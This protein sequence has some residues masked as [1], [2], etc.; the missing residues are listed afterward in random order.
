MNEKVFHDKFEKALTSTV[1]GQL[2]TADFNE[3]IS[4]LRD[5]SLLLSRLK[6][7]SMKANVE[8]IH[9][10]AIASG[11]S[12]IGTEDTQETT[13]SATIPNN[14]ITAGEIVVDFPI[15]YQF[16]EDQVWSAADGPDAIDDAVQQGLALIQEEIVKYASNEI[17]REA[18][19]TSSAGFTDSLIDVA[20]QDANVVDID[21]P[22]TG[23]S[24]LL[25][26][27]FASLIFLTASLGQ[28]EGT[29]LDME[30]NPNDYAYIVSRNHY[31]N[32]R[33]ELEDLAVDGGFNMIVDGGVLKYNDVPVHWYPNW[34]D[35]HI[36]LASYNDLVWGV[37]KN[38][39][40]ETDKDVRRRRYDNVLTA[41][42]GFG[43][44]DSSKV[45]LLHFIG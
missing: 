6:L 22:L 36:M 8:E 39:T 28:D 29:A 1:G 20:T 24:G 16:L 34:P 3:F 18:V 45:V 14:T 23:S 10:F 33:R 40:M 26:G 44:A 41:R 30:S 2:N 43:L 9:T 21:V 27:S 15:T 4:A 19:S 35:R 38:I 13:A 42:S 25:S 5:E 32:Y 7:M 12:Q 11:Q 31:N 17:A 37:R